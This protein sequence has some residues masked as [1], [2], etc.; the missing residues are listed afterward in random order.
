MKRPFPARHYVSGSSDM[1][2]VNESVIL[3]AVPQYHARPVSAQVAL[4]LTI[5]LGSSSPRIFM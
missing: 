3:D 2:G 5:N 1:G 4:G